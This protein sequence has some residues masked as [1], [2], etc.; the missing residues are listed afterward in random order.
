MRAAI[1][2]RYS[3]ENQREASIED[4]S[5]NCERGCAQHGLEVTHRFADEAMSGAKTDRPGYQAVLEGARRGEFDVIVV[6]EVSRLWRDQEEQWRAVKLLEFL[7]LHILG[8]SD[9]IDTR[10]G[11]YRLLLSIRGAMN[12]E[13]RRE[14]AWRT[15]RGQEGQARKGYSV[16][17]KLYGYR[18]MPEYHPSEKDHLGCAIVIAV[19]REV[20]PEQ[21]NW[22]LW[23][24]ERYAEGWSPRRIADE[25]NQQG[26]PSPGSSWT[27]K[28]VR[29]CRGWAASCIYGDQKKGFGILFNPLYAGKYI[30]N[31]TKRVINPE[32]KGRQHQ[33]RPESEWVV[34]EM[35]ELRIVPEELWCRVQARRRRELNMS[36]AP[37]RRLG[38]RRPRYL[39]SGFLKCSVCGGSYVMVNERS[40]GCAT[41]KD[42][43]AAICP[44]SRR[45]RREVAEQ[46]LL[47][48]VKQVLLSPENILLFRKELARAAVEESRAVQDNSARDRLVLVER[49]IANIVEAIKAGAFSH[50]LRGEL[51]RLEAEKERLAE[52][53]E[54][55]AG[56][57]QVLELL[58][59]AIEEYR[60]AIEQLEEFAREENDVETARELLRPLLG[61]DEVSLVPTHDGHLDAMLSPPY[62]ALLRL[63]AA[64]ITPGTEER[65]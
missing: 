40:Y 41:H 30:W 55:A 28:E 45:V 20:D 36:G 38:G 12:E 57:G 60:K 24:F 16:G 33:V 29:R 7:G 54:A 8:V 10:A 22:V 31:R 9:G 61:A 56:A 13:A 42:R 44:N 19:R 32:T 14:V 51:A 21:A 43:G 1:Y 25:L 6:D 62:S 18:N 46:K 23:I 47:A 49:E 35:P 50:T 58:P 37:G 52:T 2:A 53:A 64:E 4:Q 15:H 5:R 65:T 48:G 34:Q 39:L 59:E 11:G 26:V 3:S 63:S 17:G 27:R